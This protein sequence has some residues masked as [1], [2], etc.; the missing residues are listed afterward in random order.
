MS[1]LK[2]IDIS[3]FARFDSK[4]THIDFPEDEIL[5]IGENQDSSGSD[6]N[7]SCKSAFVDA[8]DWAINGDVIRDIS[9]VDE[10]IRRGQSSCFV[11]FNLIDDKQ[12]S[13]IERSK[14]PK[15]K[16]IYKIQDLQG[17]TTNDKTRRLKDQTEQEIFKDFN[18]DLKRHHFDFC[19][20]V[21]F[22]T[23]AVK[24]FA[25]KEASNTDRIA[26][27]TRFLSLDP[28]DI[29]TENAK[30]LRKEHEKTLEQIQNKI[31]EILVQLPEDF[32]DYESYSKFLNEQL[33]ELSNNKNEWIAYR[34][35]LLD[36]QNQITIIESINAQIET[37][38]LRQK[39][40]NDS[41]K[42]QQELEKKKLD[43]ENEKTGIE[44]DLQQYSSLEEYDV[45][46]KD[47]DEANKKQIETITKQKESLKTIVQ[48]LAKPLICPECKSELSYLNNILIKIN[49]Q[50]LKEEQTKINTSLIIENEQL[51]NIKT[52]KKSY[53]DTVIDLKDFQNQLPTIE[54]SIKLL[55]EQLNLIV[56][57]AEDFDKLIIDL[58]S[59]IPQDINVE[60]LK[61]SLTDADTQLETLNGEIAKIKQT[62]ENL[63]KLAN[64]LLINQTLAKTEQQKIN[65][66]RY[67]E[68]NFPKVKQIII[69][70]YLPIFEARTNYYLDFINTGFTIAL[71]TEKEKRTGGVKQEFSITVTDEHGSTAEFEVY[72]EGERKRIAVCVGFALREIALS[73]RALPFDFMMFDEIIDGLDD[74]G[75]GE[76]FKLLRSIPGQKLIISHNDN[77]KSMFSNIIKITRKNGTATAELICLN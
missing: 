42:R 16:L 9:N 62:Q 57:N 49:I 47:L 13:H 14:E 35:T 28:F 26:L 37:I 40:Y 8:I 29:A 1:R 33:L 50:K 48:Q 39:Q 77:L 3:N 34:Q 4:V 52:N 54:Q 22:S 31:N 64:E 45:A 58:Q 67:W 41:I 65:D 25:S 76:F 74:T 2:S 24:G 23:T 17:N 32:T 38:K 44:K 56:I 53:E 68:V 73:H 11:K 10:V 7:G 12:I 71:S 30:E 60:E 59:K 69:E 5:I 46:I 27:I 6:S 75:V 21:Y 20:T 55:L 18:L 19:N 72:S 15:E 36:Q 51:E 63:L 66:Y 43:F 70:S 61:E